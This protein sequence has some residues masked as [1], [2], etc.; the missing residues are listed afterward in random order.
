ML[1]GQR[2]SLPHLVAES[3]KFEYFAKIPGSF[4]GTNL[5]HLENTSIKWRIQGVQGGMN[6]RECDNRTN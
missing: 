4:W 6:L 5:E 2:V 1:D 3:L